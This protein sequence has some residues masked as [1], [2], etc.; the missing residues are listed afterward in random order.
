MNN[1]KSGRLLASCAVVAVAVAA[2]ATWAGLASAGT[3]SSAASNATSRT[4]GQQ[5]T[6]LVDVRLGLGPY[7]DYMLWPLAHQLGLDKQLGVNLKLT[8]F[9]GAIGP[10]V[11]ALRRGSIDAYSVGT[12]ANFSYVKAIPSIRNFVIVGNYRGFVVVGRKGAPSYPALIAAGKSPAAALREVYGYIKGKTFVIQKAL[13]LPVVESLLAKG[14]MSLKDVKILDFADDEKA[15]TAFL[16]GS[17]DFY[18]G[19]LPQEVKLLTGFGDKFVN[20]GGAEVIGP[21]GLYY[22]TLASTSDWLAKN[23]TTALKLAAIAMRAA[24][25]VQKKPNV[26]IPIIKS[27][28]NAHAA[29]ALTDAQIEQNLK[30]FDLYITP[31]LAASLVYKQGPFYYLKSVAYYQNAAKKAG[32]LPAGSKMGQWD[33]ELTIY[34]QLKA[35]KTLWAWVNQPIK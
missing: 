31:A 22:T 9:P 2:L 33:A 5:T 12:A 27:N 15:A 16:S 17:G 25:Y 18:T 1:F 7:F 8:W 4:A 30:T 11:Q 14:G 6:S 24:E 20:V 26:A 13:N 23:H 3:T 34:K 21:A 28:L 10:E 29:S 32:E 19:S 35:D